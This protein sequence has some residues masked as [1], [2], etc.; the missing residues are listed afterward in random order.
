[1]RK[2]LCLCNGRNHGKAGRG[3]YHRSGITVAA[4]T[5]PTV[6]HVR[7]L[8]SRCC[9]GARGVDARR[10]GRPLRGCSRIQLGRQTPDQRCR[11]AV[12]WTPPS[13]PLTTSPI[14]RARRR[15]GAPPTGRTPTRWF[16]CAPTA[17]TPPMPVLDP[18]AGAQR[19]PPDASWATRRRHWHPPVGRYRSE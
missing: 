18:T 15:S 16:C 11:G 8:Q 3:P 9:D 5:E 14:L 7:A 13:I 12:S 17:T 6:A 1:M 4:V 10:P 2:P 19:A